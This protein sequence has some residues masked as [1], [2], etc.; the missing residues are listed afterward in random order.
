[1]VQMMFS[2]EMDGKHFIGSQ[3]QTFGQYFGAMRVI[4]G[5][6]EILG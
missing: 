6:V 3:S 1:M 5:I 2:I 4:F